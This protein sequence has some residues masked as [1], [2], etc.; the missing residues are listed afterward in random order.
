M[1]ILNDSGHG[2]SVSFLKLIG[3]TAQLCQVVKFLLVFVPAVLELQLFFRYFLKFLVF[4][5]AKFYIPRQTHFPPGFS[6][7][8]LLRH[9]GMMQL[10]N[11]RFQACYSYFCNLICKFLTLSLD[12]S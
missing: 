3:F 9:N 8:Q 11:L 1:L 12:N 10:L 6:L 7:C 5:Y 4:L 2:F